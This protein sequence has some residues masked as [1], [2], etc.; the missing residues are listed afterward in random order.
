MPPTGASVTP[1]TAYFVCRKQTKRP[2]SVTARTMAA[3]GAMTH[4]QSG[5]IRPFGSF[6]AWLSTFKNLPQSR[7]VLLAMV[8]QRRN[9]L[10][11]L[12]LPQTAIALH[13]RAYHAILSAGLLYYFQ[14]GLMVY[15]VVVISQWAA[16]NLSLV[17]QPAD[18]QIIETGVPN[19][20]TAPNDGKRF[21]HLPSKRCRRVRSGSCQGGQ[22]APFRG[23]PAI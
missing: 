3:S 19:G 23:A 10:L 11:I 13:N 6:T 21:P 18:A 16:G 15:T 9:S 5:M 4:V 17:Y 2:S 7:M 1:S 20:A 12:R 22:L 8:S 14:V